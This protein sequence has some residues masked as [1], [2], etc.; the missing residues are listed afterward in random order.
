MQVYS[1]SYGQ[2]STGA[3]LWEDASEQEHPVWAS[4]K[5]ATPP[6]PDQIEDTAAPN[7]DAPTG[8][9]EASEI[10]APTENGG[11]AGAP[12]VSFGGTDAE[13]ERDARKSHEILD[14]LKHESSFLETM[15]EAFGL[16]SA[17]D[18]SRRIRRLQSRRG[19][20][21]RRGS[22]NNQ[23]ELHLEE[24]VYPRS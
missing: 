13:D 19:S 6:T 2:A 12:A 18:E 3:W 4:R 7:A 16:G 21:I 11:E 15:R 23:G 9:G 1:P 5:N 17:S 14:Q 24:C 22:V 8:N 10:I 20:G